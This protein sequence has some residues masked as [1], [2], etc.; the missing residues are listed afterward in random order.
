MPAP[1]SLP[2]APQGNATA[3]LAGPSRLSGPPREAAAHENESGSTVDFA[4]LLKSGGART[5]EFAAL[6]G[7]KA[8]LDAAATTPDTLPADVGALLAEIAQPLPPTTIP[9]VPVTATPP[10]PGATP[11]DTDAA[12]AGLR[13]ALPRD[14]AATATLGAEAG[15][16]AASPPPGQDAGAKPEFKMPDTTPLALSQALT[17]QAHALGPTASNA[18]AGQ[19][20]LVAQQP[21]NSPQWS[22]EVG[23]GLLWMA[24]NDVQTAQMAINPPHLGPIEITLTL[25]KDRASAHFA[26]PFAD[27]RE[28]LQEALPRLREILEGAGVQLGQ[29]DVGHQSRQELARQN[30]RPREDGPEFGLEH[31]TLRPDAAVNA[32]STGRH[33]IGVGL[34]DTFV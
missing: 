1:M 21:I 14:L 17:G 12:D 11:T 25:S 6:Q 15:A 16:G 33:R 22:S 27:V 7:V 26:S 2:P 29:A 18:P 28:V 20:N 23:K 13:A 34:V 5:D 24:R 30:G 19:A 8:E 10:L 3:A 9:L 31:A 32:A 4:S